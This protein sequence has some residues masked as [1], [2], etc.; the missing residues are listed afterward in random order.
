MAQYIYPEYSQRIT[1]AF[2]NRFKNIIP[3][4]RYKGF[5]AE[6]VSGTMT[7]QLSLNGSSGHI[8]V[9][10]SGCVVK[11]TA[12]PCQTLSVEGISASTRYDIIIATHSYSED[13]NPC[14]YSIVQGVEGG[15]VPTTP[16]SAVWL[17]TLEVTASDEFTVD[18]RADL[19]VLGAEVVELADLDDVTSDVSDAITDPS[20]LMDDAGYAPD[21]TDV[22]ITKGYAD[23]L[24]MQQ[25]N[26]GQFKLE[27]DSTYTYKITLS[28]AAIR[29]KN[30]S[31]MWA[32][33]EEALVDMTAEIYVDGSTHFPTTTTNY[34]LVLAYEDPL[35]AGE[36]LIEYDDNSN[37]YYTK[38]NID[39]L[40]IRDSEG[41][42]KYL[43]YACTATW[44][45]AANVI[46]EYV[47]YRTYFCPPLGR[48]QDLDWSDYTPDGDD[49][50]AA[51]GGSQ[52][53]S[54]SNVMVTTAPMQWS[55]DSRGRER[56][57]LYVGSN[58]GSYGEQITVHGSVYYP[59]IIP[60]T[61][62]TDAT[63]PFYFKIESTETS[64]LTLTDQPGGT[65]TSST[66][67]NMDAGYIYLISKKTLDDGYASDSGDISIALSDNP[68]STGPD[69]SGANFSDYDGNPWA[70]VGCFVAYDATNAYSS[71]I[72]G[73][74]V[75]YRH[76]FD[77]SEGS[78]GSHSANISSYVPGSMNIKEVIISTYFSANG[79]GDNYDGPF[80][81]FASDNTISLVSGIPTGIL[82]SLCGSTRESSDRR[83]NPSGATLKLNV[84]NFVH[85]GLYAWNYPTEWVVKT[86]WS[87]G[88][89]F[90]GYKGSW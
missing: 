80:G 36:I 58:G 76:P 74:N 39:S 84:Q 45:G 78:G 21:S 59:P 4:G 52:T 28:E 40:D 20:N 57:S 54:S 26:I 44:N 66:W 70:W 33:T 35:N 69:L 87:P 2:A 15:G 71:L 82:V 61:Y 62:S 56:L 90:Y 42:T 53:P 79:S 12:D 50:E 46:A 83:P 64:Y 88:I 17:A 49:I 14:T 29:S 85:V 37:S 67:T 65:D 73:P 18:E 43:L 63:K 68:P 48:V 86:T 41:T 51:I 60:A 72:C 13:N 10:K 23:N 11:E 34:F 5:Y 30:G 31:E 25:D 9:A 38:A 1:A 22:F 77:L 47:D 32:Y 81:F 3:G 8:L 89:F 75:Q 24:G 27:I 7:V 6:R 19:Q 55:N 16:T